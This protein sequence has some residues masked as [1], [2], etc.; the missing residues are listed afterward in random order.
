MQLAGKQ[1]LEAPQ[2]VVWDMLM[3]PDVLAKIVPGISRLEKTG[4]HS[5]K[6]ALS[7]K[8]GP[9]SGLFKGDLQMENIQDQISFT[10]QVNQKSLIGNADS[11]IKI[12]LAPVENNKTEVSFD[13]NVKLSGVL[14]SMGQRVLGGVANTLTRQFF[15][16]MEKE[17]AAATA[18]ASSTQSQEKK[19]E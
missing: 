7:I 17:L 18:P 11:S 6:S 5:Y 2:R 16:N 1:V 15:V 4:E 9:V 8:M 3:N 12:D 10:L 13:G 14:A 19:V